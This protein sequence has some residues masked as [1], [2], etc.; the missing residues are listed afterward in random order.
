MGEVFYA[1]GNV[2]ESIVIV[3]PP[4]SEMRVRRL[5]KVTLNPKE[6][7]VDEGGTCF[8]TGRVEE[9]S[10]PEVGKGL[11]NAPLKFHVDDVEAGY[12]TTDQ[13]GNYSVHLKFEQAGRVKVNVELVLP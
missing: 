8:F 7:E 9:A 11:P 6:A 10:G 1:A 5:L 12:T 13:D 4:T 3:R 2:P